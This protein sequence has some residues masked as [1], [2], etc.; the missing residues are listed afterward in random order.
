VKPTCDRA[1]GHDRSS[2]NQANDSS[3]K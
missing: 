2:S 1:G 3:T